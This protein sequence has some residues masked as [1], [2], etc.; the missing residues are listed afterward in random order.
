MGVDIARTSLNDAVDRFSKKKQGRDFH[1]RFV[2][3][4]LTEHHL[5][6]TPRPCWGPHLA[7]SAEWPDELPLLER[8][9][10][11]IVSMQ[12]AIHYMFQD[13]G[14]CAKFFKEVSSVMKVGEEGRSPAL[15]NSRRRSPWEA[16]V[17]RTSQSE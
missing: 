14:K 8:T 13:E 11:D 15:A 4:D 6:G 7:P 5:K 2:H 1:V 16:S 3:A 10:F 17:R 12:F 9:V